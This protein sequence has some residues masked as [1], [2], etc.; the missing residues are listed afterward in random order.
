MRLT[1]IDICTQGSAPVHSNTTSKPSGS[2]NSWSAAIIDS[3]RNRIA[4]SVVSAFD[5]SP[6]GRQYTWSAKPFACA[7]SRRD[8]LMS[9]ATTRLAPFVRASMQASRPM[10]PTP[11]TSTVWP[12]ETPAL[13]DAWMRTP[14]GSASAA[15]SKETLSGMLKNKLR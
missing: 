9:R 10:A 3:L 2:L 1:W 11:N 6:A 7:N 4:S 8:R 15:C 5:L 12:V 13:R 14:R